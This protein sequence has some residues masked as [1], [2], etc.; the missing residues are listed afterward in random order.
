MPFAAHRAADIHQRR[1]VG[2]P[3]TRSQQRRVRK[4][5]DGCAGGDTRGK[6]QHRSDGEDGTPREHSE[7]IPD[8][9]ENR[10]AGFR[11]EPHPNCFRS[12][13]NHLAVTGQR[14]LVS[15]PGTNDNRAADPADRF[16]ALLHDRRYDV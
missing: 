4:A 13:T 10:H 3:H 2:H 1:G 15:G 5:E 9:C 6:R 8:V 7:G 12:E 11:L 16:V 14:R